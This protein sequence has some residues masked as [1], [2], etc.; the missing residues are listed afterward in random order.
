MRNLREIAAVP[1]LASAWALQWA[2][3]KIHGR[4]GSVLI[5]MAMTKETSAIKR[6][7]RLYPYGTP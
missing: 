5:Q 4:Q 1:L 6:A 2:A 3:L 7:L